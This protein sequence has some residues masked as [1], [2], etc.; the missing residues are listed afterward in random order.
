MYSSSP[1]FIPVSLPSCAFKS[2]QLATSTVESVVEPRE[3]CFFSLC[4]FL[5]PIDMVSHELHYK[6]TSFMP[7]H[8]VGGNDISF[9]TLVNVFQLFSNKSSFCQNCLDAV[10]AR[11]LL[12]NL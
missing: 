8:S 12:E 5:D 9:I 10:V 11:N 4:F 1:I 2:E 7:K 3:K 6:N